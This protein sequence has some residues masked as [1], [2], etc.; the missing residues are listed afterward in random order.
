MITITTRQ[1]NKM[2]NDRMAY[3]T[4][5][6]GSIAFT[7][8]MENP[9]T[10]EVV[11]GRTIN[12]DSYAD[13]ARLVGVSDN[14]SLDAVMNDKASHGL[15]NVDYLHRFA[16]LHSLTY[17]ITGDRMFAAYR[18][19]CEQARQDKSD[20]ESYYKDMGL[21]GRRLLYGS[22]GGF[23]KNQ[24]KGLKLLHEAMEN[25]D[26]HARNILT[27]YYANNEQWGKAAR[28]ALDGAKSGDLVSMAYL[29]RLY[30]KGADFENF[31]DNLGDPDLASAIEWCVKSVEGGNKRE[32]GQLNYYIHKGYL[33]PDSKR[34][35]KIL[36]IQAQRT[37]EILEHLKAHPFV[38]PQ[39]TEARR[40]MESG[41]PDGFDKAVKILK[42]AI[43][44]G[45]AR[46]YRD[47]AVCY[48]EKGK[49]GLAAQSAMQ[50]LDAGH[51]PCLWVLAD[52]CAKG[53][54]L[55]GFSD[56]ITE[57]DEKELIKWYVRIVEEISSLPIPAIEMLD[58][59][60]KGGKLDFDRLSE[61]VKEKLKHYYRRQ[62]E[63][64]SGKSKRKR[65]FLYGDK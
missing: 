23:G 10:G 59:Y 22:F 8:Q 63:K 30:E 26:M 21:E 37:K 33:D 62:A 56:N 29:C 47:L 18:K 64:A 1:R 5:D 2:W 40:A 51:K 12:I 13:F 19:Y 58:K 32:I 20:K 34:Y 41:E 44:D 65:D 60:I 55:V 53:A 50:G 45:N 25:G 6:N 39:L 11:D 48:M 36:K 3:S 54:D 42:E 15:L 43:A 38:D 24:E 14:H 61:T 4:T 46:L 52:L 9:G 16:E 17:S 28:Y 7:E 31:T 49:F 35:V 27:G 57:P